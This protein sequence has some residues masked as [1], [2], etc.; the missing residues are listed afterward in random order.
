MEGGVEAGSREADPWGDNPMRRP[1][2]RSVTLNICVGRG[3]EILQ[4]AGSVLE[5]LTGQKPV[6]RKA[7]R[8]IRDFGIRKGD[9]IAVSVTVRGEKAGALL[10]RLLDAVGRRV[11]ASSFDN[12]GNFAFGIREHI[13]I[14]GMKYKAE[15]GIF[16]MDVAVSMG[17]PGYRVAKRRIKRRRIPRR[18]R[19][20]REESIY[21]AQKY[22]NMEVT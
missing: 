1:V 8:T 14:P 7:K 21:Y 11:R 9:S 15:I 3:G 19:L 2:I 5:E 10:N 22:L 18:H 20:G 6:V 16:G 4:R 13:D 17:R 12:E